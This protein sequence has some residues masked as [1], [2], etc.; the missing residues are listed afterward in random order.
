MD[1]E[2]MG[3]AES[4]AIK[5]AAVKKYRELF[6]AGQFNDDDLWNFIWLVYGYK[7][8]RK[9]FC[10]EHDA[11]FEFIADAFFG[12]CNLA[13]AVVFA[14]RGGGKTLD[15][16]LLENAGMIL[17]DKLEIYHYGSVIYQADKCYDYFKAFTDS[18]LIADQFV[19]TLRGGAKTVDGSSLAI[20]S[21]TI[22][23]CSGP[24]PHWAFLD[25]VETLERRDVFEK[26]QGMTRSDEKNHALDIYTS[27]RDKAYGHM[28]RV[29]EWARDMNIHVYKWCI[30][31]V[32]ETCPADA[33]CK[34]CSQ[35][36]RDRCQGRAKKTSGF[37]PIQDFRDKSAKVDDDTW[38]AQWLCNRPQRTGAVFK[39]FNEDVHV[40]KTPLEWSKKYP[41]ILV[42]DPGWRSDPKTNRGS[43]A[44]YDIQVDSM[45]RIKVLRENRFGERTPFEV[46]Q[47]MRVRHSVPWAWDAIISDP[48]DP[49]AARD[50]CKGYG[51][52]FR[53]IRFDKGEIQLG[54]REVRE[55]LRIRADGTTGLMIDPSCKDAIWEMNAYSYPPIQDRR[56]LNENPIDA[57]NHFPDCLR[58]FIKASPRT[59]ASRIIVGEQRDIERILEGY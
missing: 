27:T 58:Y 52:D 48:A 19:S 44:V 26:F 9:S 17:R 51:S 55:K 40:S 12:R 43:Y 7:I 15:T 14:N 59:T 32:L 49:A 56:P 18:P 30:W 22:A 28:Q 38:E 10:P 41:V 23:A 57:D 47:A 39:E 11:P 13:A 53:I 5:R 37:Y 33:N 8:P 31:D 36:T 4:V 42:M 46:G 1:R 50:F 35:R 16:A 21:A 6:Q 29:L 3:Q 54:I 24:H 2:A 34:E 25:E 20:H 45:D